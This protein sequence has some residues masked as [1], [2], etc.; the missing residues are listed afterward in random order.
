MSGVFVFYFVCASARA[1]NAGAERVCVEP[2][3]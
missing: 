1:A 2:P 3:C